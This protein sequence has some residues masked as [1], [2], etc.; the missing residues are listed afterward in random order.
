M[1]R[2]G[3]VGVLWGKAT[4]LNNDHEQLVMQQLITAYV[5]TCSIL[6][7]RSLAPEL[8]AL[9]GFEQSLASKLEMT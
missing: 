2:G 5:L 8:K 3:G 9:I 7:L 1:G 4:F 6:C